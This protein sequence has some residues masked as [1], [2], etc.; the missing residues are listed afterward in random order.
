MQH[1]THFSARITADG[2][3]E[4]RKVGSTENQSND[5]SINANEN[6]TLAAQVHGIES[7]SWQDGVSYAEINYGHQGS[8]NSMPSIDT[9]NLLDESTS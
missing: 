4:K 8:N 3:D 7:E 1:A 9:I 2:G 6:T 5:I